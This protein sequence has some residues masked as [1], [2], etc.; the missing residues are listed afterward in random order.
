MEELHK[1]NSVCGLQIKEQLV[2]QTSQQSAPI[3]GLVPPVNPFIVL[4]ILF[5]LLFVPFAQ[6]REKWLSWSYTV[7]FFSTVLK[8]QF[9][10]F[11]YLIVCINGTYLS[12]ELGSGAYKVKIWPPYED[13]QAFVIWCC[14]FLANVIARGTDC[15]VD[16]VYCICICHIT[17]PLFPK[18]SCCVHVLSHDST[19]TL[20]L[21]SSSCWYAGD[22]ELA[23]SD[24]LAPIFLS[25][26]KSVCIKTGTLSFTW[27]IIYVNDVPPFHALE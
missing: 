3:R 8:E 13:I 1:R 25:Q 18:N 26:K 7:I 17:C 22:N 11:V 2:K 9:L 5:F 10:L 14:V 23:I 12:Q 19:A 16:F 15:I 24:L 27:T 20:C 4:L 6:Q 21:Q